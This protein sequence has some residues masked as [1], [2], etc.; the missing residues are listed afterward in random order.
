MYPD[1]LIHFNKNHS[2]ANGQFVRGDGDGDG[3]GDEHHR[4]SKNGVKPTNSSPKSSKTSSRKQTYDPQKEQ[5]RAIAN[6]D[7]VVNLAANAVC[8]GA[9][10]ALGF[11]FSR[12]KLGKTLKQAGYKEVTKE[13]VKVTGIDKI[14]KD[15]GVTDKVNKVKS[16]IHGKV[17]EGLKKGANKAIDQD[18]K[19]TESQAKKV[20]T[21]LIVGG[22]AA[23][24]LGSSYVTRIV[25]PYANRAVSAIVGAVGDMKSKRSDGGR[26]FADDYKRASVAKVVGGDW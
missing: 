12:T 15:S 24:S 16:D 14:A 23:T 19:L 7:A 1:Y 3:T 17:A 20:K 11:A 21:G 6:N 8:T 26:M 25:K 22:A 5:L 13:F 10:K 4:Y 18:F 9:R 2:K